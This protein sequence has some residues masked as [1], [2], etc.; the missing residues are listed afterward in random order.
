MCGAQAV[1]E[2]WRI[3]DAYPQSRHAAGTA[4]FGLA[5]LVVMRRSGAAG[6]SPAFQRRPSYCSPT[7]AC[8]GELPSETGAN[9]NEL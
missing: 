3:V 4:D 2:A 6:G 7:M 5:L 8:G 1:P 9:A